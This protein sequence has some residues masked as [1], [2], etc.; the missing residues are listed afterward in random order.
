MD[1]LVIDVETTGGSMDNIPVGFT[2]LVTGLRHANRYA[3]YTAE[4]ASLGTL[5]DL[6]S[7]FQGR[8]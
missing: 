5:A 2:L 3:M 7:E 4:P 6:L 8:W 1:F